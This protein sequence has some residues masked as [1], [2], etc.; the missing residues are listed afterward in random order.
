MYDDSCL[1]VQGRWY[2]GF[3]TYLLGGL[4]TFQFEFVKLV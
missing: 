2:V 4:S 3:M 1:G